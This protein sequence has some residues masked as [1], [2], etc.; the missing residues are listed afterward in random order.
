MGAGDVRRRRGRGAAAAGDDQ[1]E[2]GGD[3][4]QCA[5]HGK[6]CVRGVRLTVQRDARQK[7]LAACRPK[8]FSHL[9][10]RRRVRLSF[11]KPLR[12]AICRARLR[13]LARLLHSA[14]YCSRTVAF[15]LSAI[16]ASCVR[17]LLRFLLRSP[18]AS[19]ER[20]CSAFADQPSW[21]VTVRRASA[22]VNLCR[23]CLLV[24]QDRACVRKNFF[25]SAIERYVRSPKRRR[26][27]Q[28]IDSATLANRSRNCYC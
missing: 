7:Q 18:A 23:D 16:A 11:S 15:L 22:L 27:A 2:N 3:G 5:Q 19:L 28:T 13:V 21:R 1:D 12:A 25:R 14:T 10:L 26:Q 8:T 9:R 17:R 6:P 4:N 24:K 20:I